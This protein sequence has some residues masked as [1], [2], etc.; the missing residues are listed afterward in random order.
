MEREREKQR[1]RER[2]RERKR[3]RE[4]KTERNCIAPTPDNAAAL[5]MSG[6]WIRQVR[7]PLCGLGISQPKSLCRVPFL[8]TYRASRLQGSWIASKDVNRHQSE[9]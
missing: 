3:K 9:W 7:F 1:Q 8:C 5:G 2:E 4:R 6:F